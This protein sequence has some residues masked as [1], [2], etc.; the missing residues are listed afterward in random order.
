MKKNPTKKPVKV[1]PK[2]MTFEGRIVEIYKKKSGLYTLIEHLV[3][4]DVD[5]EEMN[6]IIKKEK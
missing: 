3:H 4:R 6:R 1:V 2:V 5:Q